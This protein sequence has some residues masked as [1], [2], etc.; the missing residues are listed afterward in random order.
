[1]LAVTC[2]I[3]NRVIG[4][5][6]QPDVRRHLAKDEEQEPNCHDGKRSQSSAVYVAPDSPPS[7]LHQKTP[8]VV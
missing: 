2:A 7:Y 6:A 5:A 4:P 8:T 1:M 3:H